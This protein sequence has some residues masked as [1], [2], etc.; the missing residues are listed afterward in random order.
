MKLLRII[1]LILFF[2]GLL[3]FSILS[4]LKEPFL[5]YTLC[6]PEHKAERNKKKEN[7]C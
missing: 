6:V 4:S 1:G 7:P 3:L 2:S 5:P